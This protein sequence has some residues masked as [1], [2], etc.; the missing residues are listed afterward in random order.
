MKNIKLILEYDGTRYAGWQRQKNAIAIQQ[1]LEEAI[2]KITRCKEIVIGSSRTDSGVHARGYTANFQTECDIPGE[3]FRDAINT[4][5]PGDI[6]ILSSEEVEENFHARYCCVGKTYSYTIL[7]R[8]VPA[9]ID[10]YYMYHIR[11]TLDVQAMKKAA[12]YFVGT[13]DF[14][15]FKSQGSGVKN[16]I[17]TIKELTVTKEDDRVIISVTADGFLYNMVRI[18]SGTLIKVG[19]NKMPIIEIPDIIFSKDRKRAGKCEPACGLCL[20]KVYY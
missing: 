8:Y 12:E 20:E 6:V 3:K 9:T 17:R 10:R 11:R 14:S 19:M 4:K 7:N 2:W 5:L 13:Y 1:V 15:A 18:I 16:S